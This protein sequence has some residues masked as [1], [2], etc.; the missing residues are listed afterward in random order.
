LSEKKYETI[1]FE[2]KVINKGMNKIE[3]HLKEL[4]GKTNK[5][6]LNVQKNK[7]SINNHLETHKNDEMK[8]H[9]RNEKMLK[10]A[11]LIVSITGII[12][13]TVTFILTKL[14]GG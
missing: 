7:D 12:A 5:T 1:L 9:H 13:T 8:N 4:N 14:F 3:E 6:I 2:L 11:A 10:S